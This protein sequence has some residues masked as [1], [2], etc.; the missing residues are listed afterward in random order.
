[1]KEVMKK[2]FELVEEIQKTKQYLNLSEAKK[3]NDSDVEL[4]NNIKKYNLLTEEVKRLISTGKGNKEQ[5]DEKNVEISKL[6]D[7]IIKNENMVAFNR[8]SEEVNILMNKINSILV[9]G[10]NGEIINTYSCDDDNGCG[11]CGKC[12]K[13]N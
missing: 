7:I 12:L 6:Y 10:V 8:A 3:N 1:M 2:V 9:A 4:T 13:K 11:S 5:I